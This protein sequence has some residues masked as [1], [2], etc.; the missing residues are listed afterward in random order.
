MGNCLFCCRTPAT[1]VDAVSPIPVNSTFV[2]DNRDTYQ[3]NTIYY[4]YERPSWAQPITIV[5]DAKTVTPH[6]VWQVDGT[7]VPISTSDRPNP[8]PPF[9]GFPTGTAYG[10]DKGHVFGLANG[11]VDDSLNIVPQQSKWQQSGGWRK[12]EITCQSAALKQYKWASAGPASTAY[13]LTD[14]WAAG[15]N[16]VWLTIV[17]NGYDAKTGAPTSYNGN[18]KIWGP[19]ITI[20]YPF[21]ILPNQDAIWSKGP[22]PTLISMDEIEKQIELEIKQEKEKETKNENE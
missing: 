11:G 20:D 15:L 22:P 13:K 12:M 3:S 16:R 8:P 9:N 2:G 6:Q 10:L 5:H 19:N 14:P 1:V 21:T 18:V 17:M 7:I 4:K